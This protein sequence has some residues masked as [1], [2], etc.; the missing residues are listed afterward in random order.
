MTNV[1]AWPPVN[2]VGSR[3]SILHPTG[4]SRS[5]LTG[6]RYVSA[7]QR[8]RRVA[9]RKVNAL[10]A[11]RAAGGYMEMLRDLIG[12][13]TGLVRLDSTPVNWHLDQARMIPARTGAIVEWTDGGVETTWTDGGVAMGWI[14]GFVFTGS[15]TTD[16]G[17]PAIAV[18]GFPPNAIVARPGEY[19]TIDGEAGRVLSLARS[20][21][22]GEAVIRLRAAVTS[23]GRVLLGV[24][25][26]AA[27]EVTA[28]SEPEQPVKGAWFY[29]LQFL[30][31]FADEVPGGFTELDPWS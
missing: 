28:F 2:W 18:T 27:F 25:E 15:P 12:G 4:Q 11:A 19:L 13:G 21:G 3:W 14:S 31:V 17:W 1:Y 5:L 26:S 24:Q 16:G 10:G 6:A 22:A 23:S 29:D 8:S 7:A 30:E 20:D 9:M